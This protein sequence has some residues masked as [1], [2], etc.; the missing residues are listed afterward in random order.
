MATEW[1]MLLYCS[2]HVTFTVWTRWTGNDLTCWIFIYML[3]FKKNK[4]NVFIPIFYMQIM[5]FVY[6][7]YALCRNN[8]INTASL[9]PDGPL[10]LNT[11]RSSHLAWGRAVNSF[12][13]ASSL[14][15]SQ[16]CSLHPYIHIP[17]YS[18]QPSHWL[19]HLFHP[20]RCPLIHS[21]HPSIY[22]LL[23]NSLFVLSSSTPVLPSVYPCI[24]LFITRIHYSSICYSLHQFTY[25]CLLVHSS[26]VYLWK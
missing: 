16:L 19:I 5:Y 24:Q 7:V 26:I 9:W 21:I 23:S 25:Q 4:T 22:P 20:S 6:S 2:S 14:R 12:T 13:N 15:Q 8:W 1:Q 18:V 10:S 3:Y 17:T 11:E